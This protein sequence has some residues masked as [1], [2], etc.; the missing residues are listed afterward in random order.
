MLVLNP[1]ANSVNIFFCSPKRPAMPPLLAVCATGCLLVLL[2]TLLPGSDAFHYLQSNVIVDMYRRNSDIN[3]K[4]ACPKVR[5]FRHFELGSLMG[6]WYVIQYYASSEEAAE[7][8]CM[9]CVFGMADGGIG[10]TREPVVMNFTYM[11]EDDPVK[12]PLQGNITW[13]IPDLGMPSHW[14][15]AEDPCKCE[16]DQKS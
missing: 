16:G 11:F 12:E 13:N 8:S 7:Y 6:G 1:I 10:S 3:N 15:H 4:Y 14:V 2:G 5:P 9:R